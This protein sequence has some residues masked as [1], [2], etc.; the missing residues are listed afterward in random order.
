MPLKFQEDAVVIAASHA[1][2]GLHHRAVHSEYSRHLD[3]TSRGCMQGEEWA[4][5]SGSAEAIWLLSPPQ[6]YVGSRAIL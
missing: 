2:E 1:I 4:Q 6:R 3:T 5:R